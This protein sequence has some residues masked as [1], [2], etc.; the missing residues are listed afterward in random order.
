MKSQR[1]LRH[2]FCFSYVCALFLFVFLFTP[3]ISE[4]QTYNAA[5]VQIPGLVESSS[6]GAMVEILHEAM[7]RNTYKVNIEIFPAIRQERV[8]S[9][10]KILI[11]FPFLSSEVGEGKD[12]QGIK[13]EPIHYKE[14]FI[15]N[16]RK[17]AEITTIDDI[18]GMEI[19][20]TRGFPYAE[21]ITQNSTIKI[22]YATTDE[23]SITQL[24]RNRVDAIIMDI[25]PFESILKNFSEK[26][27]NQFRI[28]K[29]P[30]TRDPS[31][32]VFKDSPEG[33]KLSQQI[34]KTLLQMK[35]DGTF[36]KI[37]SKYGVPVTAW[38]K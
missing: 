14:D 10:T 9:G 12:I 34:S 7:N 4:G 20:L 28:S 13:S 22:L 5:G 25:T 8:F 3:S 11:A 32:I 30:I 15:V 24:L 38:T 27:R 37:Y 29:K 17:N 18:K 19:G 26:E 6:T 31:F 21:A 33:R 35:Q 16:L 36:E 1:K 23:Q 2:T